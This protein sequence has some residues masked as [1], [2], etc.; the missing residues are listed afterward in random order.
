MDKPAKGGRVV[1]SISEALFDSDLVATRMA[2]ALGELCWAIMLLWP[3]DTFGRPTYHLMGLVAHEHAWAA[4]FLLTG[5]L[6]FAIVVQQDFD[7]K[8]A[9]YFAAWNAFLWVFSVGSMLLS[10]YP[11]PAAIGG[12]ISLMV[13]ASWIWLR[14]LLIDIGENRVHCK[15]RDQCGKERG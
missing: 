6:Q 15:Y 11:P 12:E 14:P 10:V 2:L 9:R 5:I 7:G 8:F 4:A 3:G 13:A 1:Q